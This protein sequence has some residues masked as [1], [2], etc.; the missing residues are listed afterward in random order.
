[1]AT[2]DVLHSAEA[3]TIADVESPAFQPA[4]RSGEML[5][6]LLHFV[7]FRHFA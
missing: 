3:T 1:M 6:Q 5:R 7:H 2:L 4:Q